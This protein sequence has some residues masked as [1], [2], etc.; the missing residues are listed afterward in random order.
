[1]RM[2]EDPTVDSWISIVR[3]HF[4]IFFAFVSMMDHILTNQVHV[5]CNRIYLKIRLL[6]LISGVY[7]QKLHRDGIICQQNLVP[8]TR[9]LVDEVWKDQPQAEI[10]PVPVKFSGRSVSNK[11]KDLRDNLKKENA[12]GIIITTLDEVVWLYNVRGSQ[13]SYSPV[14][15][16]FAV[17]T[18]KSA[19][20]Y[21][22]ERKLV[23]R[24]RSN[25]IWGENIIT[26]KDYS[27]VSSDVALL[28]SNQL[29]SANETQ[30]NGAH[31]AEDDS[32]KIWVD[33]R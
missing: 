29:T 21:V 6:G 20:F 30:S 25:L 10:N 3:L 26:V 32:H 7:R 1:M 22:D 2:G 5:F 13:V 19:F 31:E 17:V 8:T 33:P 27:A 11:L 12:R 9:N 15:H 28:A 23:T 18:T 14:V 16:A 24:C 4:N